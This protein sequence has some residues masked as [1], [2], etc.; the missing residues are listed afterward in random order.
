MFNRLY[1]KQTKRCEELLRKVQEIG[2]IMEIYGYNH[3]MG[4]GEISDF[5][6][7]FEIKRKARKSADNYYLDELESDI[8]AIVNSS[9]FLIT[10]YVS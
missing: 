5:L 4:K 2:T 7:L 6:N 9:S 1:S 8:T 10:L 3:N